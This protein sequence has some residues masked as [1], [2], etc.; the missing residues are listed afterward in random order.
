MSKKKS[1]HEENHFSNSENIAPKLE[2]N[3]CVELPYTLEF[4]RSVTVGKH[5]YTSLTFVREPTVADL[6]H[7]PVQAEL[8][9]MGHFMP[10]VSGMVQESSAVVEALPVPIFQRCVAVATPFL[11]DSETTEQ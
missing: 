3:A 9:K 1:I 4:G 5:E 6:A 10:I 7:M 2:A 8:Q 11:A